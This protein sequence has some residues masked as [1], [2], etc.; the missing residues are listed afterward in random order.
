MINS[1]Q[2]AALRAMANSLQPI[3]QIGKGGLNDNMVHSVD[4]ALERRELIKVTLLETADVDVRE[5][6]SY[7][8]ENTGAEPVQCIGRKFVVYRES[9]KYKTIEI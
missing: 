2:R 5:A 6:C 9:K 8:C 7:V 1:R 4:E 3:F